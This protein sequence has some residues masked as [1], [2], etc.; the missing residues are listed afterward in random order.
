MLRWPLQLLE[1]SNVSEIS[2]SLC[3]A[4]SLPALSTVRRLPVATARYGV[5]HGSIGSLARKHEPRGSHFGGHSSLAVDGR[6]PNRWLCLE[7]SARRGFISNKALAFFS[8]FSQFASVKQVPSASTGS[9]R[10][11][12]ECLLICT[13]TP[14]CLHS[15][16]RPPSRCHCT[17]DW[18]GRIVRTS[19]RVQDQSACARLRVLVFLSFLPRRAMGRCRQRIWGQVLE[20][21]GRR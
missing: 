10:L 15:H 2:S 13:C 3:Q 7:Y 6:S 4:P 8:V 11:F 19:C 18:P 21:R 17:F 20:S 12:G 9:E 16:S 1:M 14:D 5:P